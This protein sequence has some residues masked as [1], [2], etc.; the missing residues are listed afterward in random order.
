MD[1]AVVIPARK[2][3]RRDVA[4]GPVRVVA[5]GDVHG[6]WRG[7]AGHI[8]D[9]ADLVGGPVD[10]AVAVGDVEAHHDAD[11]AAQK[12]GPAKYAGLGEF[13]EYVDGDFDFG[14]PIVFIGGNHEPYESLDRFGSGWWA[15]GVWY[16]GRF[17]AGLI[18]GLPAVWLSGIWSDRVSQR[19]STERPSH[20]HRHKSLRERTYYTLDELRAARGQASH[21]HRPP[22]MLITHDWPAG[23][24]VTKRGTPAGDPHLTELSAHLAPSVHLCGHMHHRQTVT[25]E[26]GTVV[27][28]MGHGN[29]GDDAW[30][31]LEFT[32]DGAVVRLGPGDPTVLRHPR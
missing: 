22:S 24:G 17:G 26:A 10:V 15:P 5:L 8:A 14:A 2:A 7:V 3:R 18:A 12:T 27:E 29:A 13:P 28:S 16:L 25:T 6:H 30:A 23:V 19:P 32:P 21:L 31:L 9:A 4:S 11:D 20:P 1:T